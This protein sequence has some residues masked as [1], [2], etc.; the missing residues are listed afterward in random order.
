MAIFRGP[1]PE[2]DGVC[3]WTCQALAIRISE[4]FGKTIHPDSVGRLLRRNGLSRQKTRPVHPKTDP[5]AQERIRG[6]DTQPEMRVR[7]ALWAAGLR[8]RLHDKSLPGRPDFVFQGG[9][10]SS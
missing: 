8:Y 4:K 1:K 3:T 6:K 9:T 5:K 7:R 10:R 2:V